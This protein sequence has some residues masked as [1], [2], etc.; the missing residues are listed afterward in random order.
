MYI[1]FIMSIISNNFKIGKNEHNTLLRGNN[2]N[3]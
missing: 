1:R 2:E 3:T